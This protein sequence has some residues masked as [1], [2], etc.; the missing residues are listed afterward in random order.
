M[1]VGDRM[2]FGVPD[3]I[4]DITRSSGMVQR[5]RLIY[6]MMVFGLRK[7][8]GIHQTF[9]GSPEGVPG[10][11]RDLLWAKRAKRGEHTSPQ[12]VG[13]PNLWPPALAGKGS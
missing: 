7:C 11:H 5:L 1:Y 3:E 12:E 9:I 2:L 4:T 6:G 13:A 10:D 8:F